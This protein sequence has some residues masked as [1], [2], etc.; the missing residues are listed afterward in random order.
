[1]KIRVGVLH[2]H[3]DLRIQWFIKSFNIHLSNQILL[4]EEKLCMYNKGPQTSLR[5]NNLMSVKKMHVDM[6]ACK[7]DLP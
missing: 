6:H 4:E 7:H 2:G 3:L 1:M 5:K